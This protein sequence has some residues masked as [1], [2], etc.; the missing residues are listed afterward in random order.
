MWLLGYTDAQEVQIH[1]FWIFYE[2]HCPPYLRGEVM[3]VPSVYEKLISVWA[4][5]GAN[6]RGLTFAVD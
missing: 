3:L 2:G 6:R 4:K 1:D 5:E